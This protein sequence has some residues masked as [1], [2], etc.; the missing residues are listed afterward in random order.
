M[1]RKSSRNVPRGQRRICSRS[2]GPTPFEGG[3]PASPRTVMFDWA[4]THSLTYAVPPQLTLALSLLLEIFLKEIKQWMMSLPSSSSRVEIKRPIS[5]PGHF[6]AKKPSKLRRTETNETSEGRKMTTWAEEE[7]VALFE[8]VDKHGCQ[9]RKIQKST[10]A[11]INRTAKALEWRK[12]VQNATKGATIKESS[13]AVGGNLADVL[14][15]LSKKENVKIV[16][17]DLHGTSSILE[18][19][20]DQLGSHT[21]CTPKGLKYKNV[22]FLV[23]LDLKDEEVTHVFPNTSVIVVVDNNHIAGSEPLLYEILNEHELKN[24]VLLVLVTNCIN[25]RVANGM[26]RDITYLIRPFVNNDRQWIVRAL[27]L[28]DEEALLFQ[29][30]QYLNEGILGTH[31]GP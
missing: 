15:L 4:Y 21:T 27:T 7:E 9:W 25:N 2:V 26:V 1:E 31:I 24:A 20:A 10:P 28:I 12:D 30:L 22:E 29:S 5:K 6:P 16:I 17:F 8:A 3:W 23:C 11:L 19:I 18:L 13:T 14:S